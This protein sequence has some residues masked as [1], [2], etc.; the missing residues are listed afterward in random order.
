[1]ATDEALNFSGK[2]SVRVQLEEDKKTHLRRFEIP[3]PGLASDAVSELTAW[4]KRMFGARMSFMN[5]NQTA[6]CFTLS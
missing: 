4:W 3:T 2:T 6:S 5:R 1:M